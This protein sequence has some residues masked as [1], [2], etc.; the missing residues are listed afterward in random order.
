MKDANKLTWEE[1]ER[2]LDRLNYQFIV[3]HDLPK[4]NDQKPIEYMEE[5]LEGVRKRCREIGWRR[6]ELV[7]KLYKK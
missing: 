7:K 1:T 5:A 4:V 3:I 2:E 6:I